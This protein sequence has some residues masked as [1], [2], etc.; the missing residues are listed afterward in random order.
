MFKKF[1]KR[2]SKLPPMSK[3]AQEYFDN[4][5]LLSKRNKE[6]ALLG[7]TEESLSP[8]SIKNLLLIITVM[9]ALALV[10]ILVSMGLGA[11]LSSL[12]ILIICYVGFFALIIIIL[13]VQMSWAKYRID[14]IKEEMEDDN[15]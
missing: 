6:E 9:F 4:F 5:R 12:K 8:Q 7:E 13:V 10:S 11:L 2:K 3:G 1:K 14:K 15:K